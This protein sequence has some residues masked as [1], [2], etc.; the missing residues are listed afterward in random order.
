M[1]LNP[2]RLRRSAGP[3]PAV[4]VALEG[5]AFPSPPRRVGKIDSSRPAPPVRPQVS[6]DDLPP[7]KSNNCRKTPR[8][9]FC[10]KKSR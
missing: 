7:K 8:I 10:P 3:R 6:L 1:V 4:K 5:M 2:K 9:F